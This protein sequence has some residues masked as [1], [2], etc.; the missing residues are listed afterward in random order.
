V[1][2]RLEAQKPPGEFKTAMLIFQGVVPS[3]DV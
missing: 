3:Y 2:N 1:R